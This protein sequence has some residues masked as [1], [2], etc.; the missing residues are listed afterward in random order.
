MLC[1]IQM[2]TANKSTDWTIPEQIKDN[3]I[4]LGLWDVTQLVLP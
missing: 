2:S 4:L 1:L 3:T